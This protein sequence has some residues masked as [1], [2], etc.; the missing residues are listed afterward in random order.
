MILNLFGKMVVIILASVCIQSML[1]QATDNEDIR[2][3]QPCIKYPCLKN[4][5]KEDPENQVNLDNA[6]RNGRR[7]AR[8]FCYCCGGTTNH[9]IYGK[10]CNRFC[11]KVHTAKL[12]SGQYFFTDSHIIF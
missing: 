10:I 5:L 1:S 12:N 6:C 2:S 9:H 7:N 8:R 4:L 11:L 3:Q